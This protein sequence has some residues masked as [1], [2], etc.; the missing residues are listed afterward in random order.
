MKKLI[1]ASLLT[2]IILLSGKMSAQTSI[3]K[4]FPMPDQTSRTIVRE[5]SAPVNIVY[6]E[7]V[8]RH[9]FVYNDNSGAST[10]YEINGTLSVS[11]FVVD[12][13][14]VFF[15]G[16]DAAGQPFWGLFQIND[17]FFGLGYYYVDNTTITSPSG[18][19]ATLTK[20]V[21]YYDNIRQI[22][23]IGTTSMGLPCVVYINYLGGW[24]IK[25]G[26]LPA[27]YDESLLDITF[28]GNCVATA[29]FAALST[30][31][32]LISIRCYKK[33]YNLFFDHI[34]DTAYCFTTQSGEYSLDPSQLVVNKLIPSYFSVAAYYRYDKESGGE[35][36]YPPEYGTHV[37]AYT[38][39]IGNTPHVQN[40]HSVKIPS[41]HTYGGWRLREITEA[42]SNT[43]NFSLL[44]DIENDT[45]NGN[46]STVYEL[47]YGV[48]S[49][50]YPV[51]TKSTP[52]YLLNSIDTYGTT[53]YTA[54]GVC[55][56]NHNMTLAINTHTSMTCFNTGSLL[57]T[58]VPL[59]PYIKDDPFGNPAINQ[60]TLTAY[61][62]TKIV[63][64]KAI[65][66][67][68]RP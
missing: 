60:H 31:Q 11:D 1:I 57:P 59:V 68:Q 56:S 51:A 13:D 25:V 66:K 61:M 18:T 58:P 15:C 41:F 63:G 65:L 50:Y 20:M 48:M 38:V 3:V 8:H 45:L 37:G 62:A 55:L 23:A 10:I 53:E 14:S 35:F 17:F 19:V 42:R 33:D 16:N 52:D 28:T 43:V 49:S 5:Y 12:N 6:V 4:E 9:F 44:H 46:Q 26:E 34:C 29:G 7:G 40:S 47:S 24:N 27:N 54:S 36:V 64:V 67:C 32:P 22:A 39:D 21:S 30:P 2:T